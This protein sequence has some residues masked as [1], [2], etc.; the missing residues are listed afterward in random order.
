MIWIADASHLGLLMNDNNFKAA[1]RPDDNAYDLDRIARRLK[2]KRL[3]LF[4][5]YDRT[6]TPIVRRPEEA[7]PS[8]SLR[9][10]L[11]RLAE[12]HKVAILSER[13]W[14]DVQQTV[15]LDQL[16][17]AGSHGFDLR[18]P[19]GLRTQYDAA[20]KAL[21]ELDAAERELRGRIEDI[22]GAHIERTKFAITAH[23][24]E[25]QDDDEVLEVG[26]AV[27]D[28]VREHENLRKGSGKS[29][30]ELQPNVPWDKG[31]ALLWLKEVLGLGRQAYVL[32]YIGD[33]VTDEDAFAILRSHDL[34]IGIRVA[35]TPM[36]T[37]AHY[38][39][40][41]C[42]QVERLLKSLVGYRAT[43]IGNH[44]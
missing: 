32:L 16:F 1:I 22:E 14:R 5:D 44:F 2:G 12:R 33:D 35:E 30:F 3:A 42:T 9:G 39:V 8:D 37:D 36:E 7:T 34:G 4:L 21:P 43:A 11:S 19:K 15:G 6:L 28:V 20:A 23:Y 29:G 13:D 27:D 31:L 24:R 18:G 40:R 17:Y 25:V 38:C 41:N 26:Q 10:L